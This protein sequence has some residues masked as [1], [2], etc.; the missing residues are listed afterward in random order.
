MGKCILFSYSLGQSSMSMWMKKLSFTIDKWSPNPKVPCVFVGCASVKCIILVGLAILGH[1]LARH[2]TAR[3]T[4][5]GG[6]LLR[7]PIDISHSSQDANTRQ[8]N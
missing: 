4:K 5:R 2:G 6:V 1:G 7:R 3:Q 8:H